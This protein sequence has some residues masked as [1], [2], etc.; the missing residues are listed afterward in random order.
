M[1]KFKNRIAIVTGGASGIGRAISLELG[2]KGATVIV[3]DINLEGAEETAK[4]IV[5]SGGRAEAS[6]LDVTSEEEIQKLIDQTVAEHRWLD[7]MFNIAGIA[8]QGEARD[9]DRDHWKRIMDINLMGVVHGTRAAYAQMVKQGSGHI[10]NMASLLGI[11][12][13]GLSVAYATT[14]HAIVGLS[15]SLRAEGDGLGVNVSVVCPGFV[16]TGLYNAATITNADKDVFYSQ[17]PFKKMDVTKAAKATLKGVERNEGLIVYPFHAK[18]LWWLH[19]M[20]PA[21]LDM[22]NRV[23]LK[24]F[25]SIRR[26]S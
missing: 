6:K 3:A 24:K 1:N 11:V 19:R 12:G 20:N 23:T 26:E 21:S 22:A 17:V 8:I 5:A 18:Y 25:R 2:R 7:Y 14:K 15:T 16:Q 4:S 10:V 13:L 9:M